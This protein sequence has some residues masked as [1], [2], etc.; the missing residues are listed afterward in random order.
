MP[1]VVIDGVEYV[2]VKVALAN[3]LTIAKGLLLQYWGECAD[4]KAEELINKT[5]IRVLVHDGDPN[6]R[7]LAETL[8]DIAR[9][10]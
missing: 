6:G 7:S 4:E 8:E 5:Y 9:I 10:A 3:R 2:P 1:R